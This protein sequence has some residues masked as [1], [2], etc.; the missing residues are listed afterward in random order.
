V[1]EYKLLTVLWKQ[2]SPYGTYVA[3]DVVETYWSDVSASFKVYKNGVAITSGDNIPF[4]FIYNGNNQY[5]YKSENVEQL[6]ICVGLNKLKYNRQSV[7][8][9]LSESYLDNHPSCNVPVVCDLQFDTLPVITNATTSSSDDGQIVVSATSS[10]GAVQYRLNAD[11]SYGNGQTSGTFSN[12]RAGTYLV[13][14]RDAINCR[15]VISTK[16]EVAITYGTKYRIEFVDRLNNTQRTEIKEKNYAGAITEVT[17]G[18]PATIYRLRGE[19]ERDK[20]VPVLAGEVQTTFISETESEFSTIYTNDPDKFRLVHTVDGSAVWTGKVLTNQ[21][22]EDYINAPY[23]VTLLASDSLPELDDILFLDDFGNRLIGE[24]KQINVIA[25][26]LKKLKLGLSIRSA[27]NIYAS[28]MAKTASDDPLD[29]AYVDVSRYY[30]IKENPTCGEVLRYLLEP[31]NAQIIQWNNVWN[32]IRVEER[33]DLFDYRQY[34]SNGTYVSNSTYSEVKELKNSSYSNRMVWANQNQKL[35]IMPGYGSIR[36]L[37]DL[38]NKQNILRNGDF[39]LT[40]K[41]TYDIGLDDTVVQ[42][43]PDLTGFQI[44]SVGETAIYV[45]YEDLKESNIA[46]V[47]T[48]NSADGDDYLLSETINLKVGTID[49]IKFNLRF[50]IFRSPFGDQTTLYSFRYVKVRVEIRYGDYYLSSTGSWTTT[51]NVMTY[52]VNEDKQNEFIDFE[53]LASAPLDGTTLTP[54]PDFVTGQNFYAKIYFPNA[55]E[56]EFKE[57]TTAA[58]IALLK[59]KKT[60]PVGTAPGLPV[61]T[62]TELYDISNT[63]RPTGFIDS[64]ILFYELAEDT[65]SESLGDIV[66]PNDYNATTNPVQ[67]ILKGLQKYD[68]AIAT[69]LAIDRVQLQV[70]SEGLALPDNQTLERS[71]ENENPTPVQ[72]QI[73]HGSIANNGKTFFRTGFN[74]GFGIDIFGQAPNIIQTS[75]NIWDTQIVYVANSADV[76]YAGYLRSSASVGYDKWERSYFGE[77]KT[78]QDI[79]MENFSMQY[80]TPWRMLSGSMYSDDTYFNPISTLKETI[81]NN[82]LYIP[83]SLEI[84]FY[85][86]SYEC[87]LL[88]LFPITTDSAVGFTTGF[89]IGFNS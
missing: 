43:V 85:A 54:S 70:L 53:I 50:K 49:K 82:R 42:L 66:R 81:D 61:G 14:A 7:F 44:I 4:D 80:N 5:Y 59:D 37:Y 87:E 63:Y 2:N 9:Y 69:S 11:F 31:Y 62:R 13:Y 55:N 19:G 58:A 83:I 72:K 88:E 21:Y 16:V 8:P 27:C 51:P 89:S 15:A 26:I 73:F 67:W 12:L 3:N 34:D 52:Y 25:F 36:L 65:N 76:S 22:E 41:Y 20:F 57:A 47:F 68:T 38:G 86:N 48:S 79:Y 18:L 60:A 33:Y 6:L 39:K 40:S 35:R 17:A 56:A 74:F 78:L 46:V 32:I 84:D 64:Y 77:S 29:Q 1:A 10:N 28:S 30:L 24:F 23:P 75:S 45:S 71:M